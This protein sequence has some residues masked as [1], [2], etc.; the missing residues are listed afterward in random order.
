MPE[1]PIFP[2]IVGWDHVKLREVWQEFAWHVRRAGYTRLDDL[3]AHNQRVL[4]ELTGEMK[5]RGTQLSLF[6]RVS[7]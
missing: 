5:R 2:D 1:K 7:K 6:Y 3:S 4:A